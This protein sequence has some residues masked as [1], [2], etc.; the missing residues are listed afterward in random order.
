[1]SRLDLIGNRL[2]VV[3]AIATLSWYIYAISVG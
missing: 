1:M 3:T 2:C